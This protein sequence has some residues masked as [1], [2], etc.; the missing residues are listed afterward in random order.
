MENSVS[1]SGGYMGFKASLKVDM[2]KFKESMSDKTEFG[3]HKVS[4]T[5]GGVDMPEPIGIRIVPIYE[6]F[7]VS[8]YAKLDH[9][10]SARCVHSSELVGTRRE[11]VKKALEE[12]PKLKKAEV[13]TGKKLRWKVR[14]RENVS[15]IMIF[16]YLSLRFSPFHSRTSNGICMF[17]LFVTFFKISWFYASALYL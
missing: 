6:A 13:P 14:S 4:F 12:Y 8:F 17:I 2:K 3:E 10:N 1:V 9:Q 16:I 7:D 5:S 11:H 15:D